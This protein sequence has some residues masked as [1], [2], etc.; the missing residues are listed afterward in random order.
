M[1]ERDRIE[2]IMKSYALTPSQF[3]D[4]TGIQRATVSHILSGRNKAS[5][6]VMLKIFEAFPGL[7]MQWLVT[8]KGNAPV[9]GAVTLEEP[10]AQP[11]VAVQNELFPQAA[12]VVNTPVERRPTKVEQQPSSPVERAPKRAPRS[13]SA[14]VPS[15]AVKKI[16]EIRIFYTDGTYETMIPEK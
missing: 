5:L 3:A 7:D 4:K 13:A 12:T 9:A 6:E 10:L 1:N 16:K 11:A 2:L 14:A 15:P 8:G